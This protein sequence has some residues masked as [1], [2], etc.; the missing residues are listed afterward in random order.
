MRMRIKNRGRLEEKSKDFLD[1][2]RSYLSDAFPNPDRQ[3]CPPD[4]ALQSLAVNP[5]ASD[6][7][8]T[9]HIANCSPC[10]RRYSDLLTVAKLQ[11]A[12]DRALSWRRI[13]GWSRAHPL[14]IGAALVCALFIAIGVN[15]LWNKFSVPNPPPLETHQAPN[16]V[17]PVNPATVYSTFSLD[18]TK[19][20]AVRGSKPPT[21]GSLR[22]VPVPGSP[23]DLTLTL[24]LGSDEQSY[25]VKLRTGG[26]IFW[27]A[28]APSHLHD[29]QIL[30]R[31]QVD[32]RQVPVGN[33]TL[34]VESSSGIRLIQ[35]VLIEPT[36]PRSTG[37]KP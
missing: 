37:Q 7:A 35:P 2:A 32:F 8:I 29:G 28:S 18:L 19:I 17:E 1:F 36:L 22:P 10:F 9:E 25:L 11:S 4:V 31:M 6:A 30:I 12:A 34:E 26:H 23:L 14:L 33:Y 16:P 3:G 27:S 24:P 15:L 20:S 5:S 21:T 13:F